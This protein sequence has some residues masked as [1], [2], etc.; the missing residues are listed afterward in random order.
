MTWGQLRL[1]LDLATMV[2]LARYCRRDM[3][4]MVVEPSPAKRCRTALDV[5]NHLR[6]FAD[7]LRALGVEAPPAGSGMEQ[8][9]ASLL[10]LCN[11]CLAERESQTALVDQVKLPARLLLPSLKAEVDECVKR[12]IELQQELA[13]L[14]EREDYLTAAAAEDATCQSMSLSDMLCMLERV[15]TQCAEVLEGRRFTDF[16]ADDMTK[17]RGS[18]ESMMESLSRGRALLAPRL[19]LNR[20]TLHMA[21]GTG[22]E[23]INAPAKQDRRLSWTTF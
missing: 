11:I 6:P 15:R 5:P 18:V 22:T 16:V 12:N 7:R 13:L 3:A 19:A 10:Q 4:E 17:T 21:K 8:W 23:N 2:P 14:K 1:Q 9:H 20:N